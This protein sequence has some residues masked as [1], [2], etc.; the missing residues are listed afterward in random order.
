[1]T[2]TPRILAGS[3]RRSVGKGSPPRAP[4]GVARG[5]GTFSLSS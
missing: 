3:A 2:L 5:G 1:M 4:N